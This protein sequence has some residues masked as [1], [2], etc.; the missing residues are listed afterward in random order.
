MISHPKPLSELLNP[1]FK[2]IGSIFKCEFEGMTNVPVMLSNLE[3]TRETLVKV[4]TDSLTSS[5]KEFLISF[6]AKTPQW[7]LLGIEG[8][9]KMPAVQ[10]KLKNLAGMEQVKHRESLIKLRE[11]LQY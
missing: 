1:R 6:K 9:E 11:L 2:D 10:W 5:E 7:N 4:L 8:V 3:T